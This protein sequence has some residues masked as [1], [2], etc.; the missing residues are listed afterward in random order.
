MQFTIPMVEPVAE[1]IGQWAVGL[2]LT[3]VI[4]ISAVYWMKKTYDNL[5]HPPESC[6]EKPPNILTDQYWPIKNAILQHLEL[7]DLLNL[8]NAYPSLQLQR[9][10]DKRTKFVHKVTEFQDESWHCLV[11]FEHSHYAHP[12]FKAIKEKSRLSGLERQMKMEEI[13]QMIA[14]LGPDIKRLPGVKTKFDDK[15]KSQN[16][17]LACMIEGFTPLLYCA[18]LDDLETVRLLVE[19]GSDIYQTAGPD[20]GNCLHATVP[21]PSLKVA[22][23]L[24]EELK[25]DKE[26]PRLDGETALDLAS[27]MAEEFNDAEYD[28][29]DGAEEKELVQLLTD[30]Q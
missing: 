14:K 27:Y 24:I 30:R 20:Q 28:P 8:K 5:R 10:E 18:F 21:G 9:W 13:K 23:F 4:F 29:E 11:E 1:L 12:I 2:L 25:M 19:N 6:Q 15:L 7:E 22:R 17:E 3:S 16:T 26:R